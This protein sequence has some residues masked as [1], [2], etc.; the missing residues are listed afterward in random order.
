M[1]TSYYCYELQLPSTELIAM[2]INKVFIYLCWK[3]ILIVFANELDKNQVQMPGESLESEHHN[4]TDTPCRAK[5]QEQH[6]LSANRDAKEKHDGNPKK[7]CVMQMWWYQC[8]RMSV[9]VLDLVERDLHVILSL[10][11]QSHNMVERL[12]EAI[13]AELQSWQ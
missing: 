2:P 13:N 5:L 11:N 7:S 3:Y 4:E 9:D 10:Y 1:S 12:R 8:H 6:L